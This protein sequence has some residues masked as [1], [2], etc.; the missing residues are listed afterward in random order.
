MERRCL[1]DNVDHVQNF[2]CKHLD[3]IVYKKVGLPGVRFVTGVS[4][5]GDMSGQK[6]DAKP[7]N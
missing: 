7:D 3:E 4:G 1:T 2:K 5:F 6:Y